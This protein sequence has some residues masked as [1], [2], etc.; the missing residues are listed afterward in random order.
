VAGAD[1]GKGEGE[2]VDEH[3]KDLGKLEAGDVAL[4]VA[5]D[6]ERAVVSKRRRHV[7]EVP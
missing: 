1:F 7:V 4:E 2:V 6:A 3:T 5:T